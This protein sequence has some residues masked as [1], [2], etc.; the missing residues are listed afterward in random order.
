M[1]ASG[2]PWVPN[3]VSFLFN[4]LILSIG[5]FNV[6]FRSKFYKCFS[7]IFSYVIISIFLEEKSDQTKCF[8]VRWKKKNKKKQTPCSMIVIPENYNYGHNIL[9][10]FDILPKFR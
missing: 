5:L 7:F 6:L 3:L 8:L 4:L 9:E 1:V 2:G 10:F